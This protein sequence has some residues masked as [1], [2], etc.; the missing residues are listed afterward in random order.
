MRT[1]LA[2]LVLLLCVSAFGPPFA[3]APAFAAAGKPE[4]VEVVSPGG[5]RAWLRQENSVPLV[6][7]DFRF[8]GGSTLVAPEK[9][10]AAALA[11]S[12]LTEGAADRDGEAFRQVLADNSIGLNFDASREG[13]SGSLVT[14]TENL[15]LAAGLL[16]DALMAPRLDDAALAR[17]RDSMVTAARRRSQDP[18]SMAYQAWR[19]RAYAGHPYAIGTDGTEE[20]LP[21]IQRADIEAFLAQV[22]T[23]RTLIIGV[24]GDIGPDALGALLDRAFGGLPDSPAPPEPPPVP[25]IPAGTK[26]VPHPAGQSVIVFG[27]SGVTRGDPDW[28]AALVVSQ[29]L[30]GSSFTSRLGREVRE[31]RGLAYGIGVGLSA[32]KDNGLLMGQTATRNDAVAETMRIIDE[33]WRRLAADGPTAEEVDDAKT[34]LI[35]SFPLSLDSTDAVASVLVTMQYYGLPRT[36]WQERAAQFEAVSVEDAKRV[37]LQ[38]LNADALLSVIVGQPEGVTSSF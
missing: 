29:I 31:K 20:T 27:H 12:M 30:G 34:Y 25:A 24:A 38:L 8:E 37:A 15:D 10:G 11:A 21:H 6:A 28:P 23:R 2:P 17:V 35:G 19:E 7:F 1:L 3:A 9:A 32:F 36:Y 22:R 13:F 14:L 18:H 16:R 5:I 33:E 4:I 26:V